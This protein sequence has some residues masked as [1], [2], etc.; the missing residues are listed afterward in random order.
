MITLEHNGNIYKV[1]KRTSLSN[2]L[3]RKDL[4]ALPMSKWVELLN[5]VN[6]ICKAHILQ[7]VLIAAIKQYDTSLNV[8]SFTF[9]DKQYWL[10]KNTRIGLQ[11]LVNCSEDKISL[12]LEGELL[13]LPIEFANNF[14]K[15]L[16]VYAGKCYL[17][18][19][20]HLNNANLLETVEDIVNYD[21]TK[22]YPEK[23]TLNG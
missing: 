11:H 5:Q 12:M 14:L 18:T 9:K 16:E 8:N 13:E 2:L 15:Q 20:Q 23:I 22:G 19:Q 3:L 10:D 17:V 7:N 6:G 21:Y 4:L 1:H